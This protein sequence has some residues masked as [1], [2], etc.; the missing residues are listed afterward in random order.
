[1]TWEICGPIQGQPL[2]EKR[3][4]QPRDHSFLQE[5][6]GFTVLEIIQVTVNIKHKVALYVGEKFLNF[7][8]LLLQKT[9][10][11]LCTYQ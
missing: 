5:V 4:K 1:M 3:Q 7:Y 8:M 9:I 11:K 10:C 2:D 6:L